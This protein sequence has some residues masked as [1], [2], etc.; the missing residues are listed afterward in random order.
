M[1]RSEVTKKIKQDLKRRTGLTFSVTGDRGTAWGWLK[2]EAP[3]SRRVNHETNPAF[4]QNKLSQEQ[5][6]LPWIEVEPKDGET[7]WYTSQADRELLAEALGI[8]MNFS[9]CQGV[10]ISPDNWDFYLDRAENGP[11]PPEVI[12]EP[13]LPEWYFEPVPEAP[14]D[15]AIEEVDCEVLEDAKFPR[16][17]KQSH[18][19]EYTS[20]LDNPD[21]YYA[22]QAKVTHIARLTNEQ[23]D[24]L[25]NG[26]L[27][28]SL[29]WLAGKGGSGST[30]DLRD[31]NS[32]DE[33]T[34]EEQDE[35]RAG[36]YNLSIKVIAPDRQTIY[37]DPQ[38]HN[39]ARYVGFP[40]ESQEQENST[41]TD[42]KPLIDMARVLLET[43]S[44]GDVL[45]ILI[46]SGMD[47]I[48]ALEIMMVIA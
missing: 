43:K 30:A 18:I 10:S 1:S 34:E 11:P 37:I 25:V 5:D 31:V 13:E 33:Y 16:L 7:A 35:W 2:I 40:V 3:K 9:S 4:D 42:N 14:T 27:M 21:D 36:A 24:A 6:E 17:N 20:Q 39:Y 15:V 23:Y 22:Q 29:E 46:G 28:T 48:K 8:G 45:N 26:N 19:E 38:G 12:E 41:E 32:W 44:L 47:N